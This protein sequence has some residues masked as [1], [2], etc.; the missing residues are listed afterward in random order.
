MG[1]KENNEDI[2]MIEL[3]DPKDMNGGGDGRG[4]GEP[5]LT[6]LNKIICRYV[7][8]LAP[9]AEMDTPSWLRH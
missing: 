2:E 3:G 1:K 7:K 8:T 5:S 9:I 6:H 4:D